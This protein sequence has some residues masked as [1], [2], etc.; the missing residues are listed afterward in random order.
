MGTIMVLILMYSG[1]V[2]AASENSSQEVMA[3]GGDLQKI[4][5][6]EA[7]GLTYHSHVQ[8][9][10]WEPIWVTS[11]GR[12]G[13]EGQSL[14]LEGIEIMLTGDLP[15][16]AK[17]EY[18]AHVENQGWE[19]YWSSNGNAAGSQA[20]SLR[21]EAIQIRLVN[22]PDYTIEYRTHV[23]NKG[24]ES[25]WSKNGETAGTEGQSLRLE[26]IQIR[27]I[28]KNADLTDYNQILAMAKIAVKTDYTSYSWNNLQAVIKANVATVK[29][30][31]EQVDA[32]TE[33]IET[34]YYG[35]ESVANAKVY[36]SAGTYGPGTGLETV[37]QDVIIESDGVILQNI[38]ITGDLIISE[39]VGQGNVTLNNITVDGETYVRGGGKNSIHINGGNYKRITIQ[40]T[41]SGQV[42]IVATN[43]NGLD[44]IIA[45]EAASEEVILEGSFDAVTVNAAKMKISTRSNTT[46]R[47]MTVS[48]VGAGSQITLDDNSRIDRMVFNGKA[49]IKGR[50]A[51]GN[52]Q[53]NANNVTY[54]KAPEQQTVAKTV[55]VPPVIQEIKVPVTAITLAGAGNL[56]SLAKGETLQLTAAIAPSNATNT[57]L[58]WTIVNG[59]GSASVSNTGVVTGLTVGTVTA[60]ATARDGSGKV[61]SLS[62]TIKEPTVAAIAT[63]SSINSGTVNPTFTISLTNDTFTDAAGT[64]SNWTTAMGS[65]GLK[66]AS[67]LRY[68]SN[69]VIIGTTG[70]AAAGS[71]TFKANAAALT[72]NLASNTVTVAVNPIMVS[73]ITVTGFGGAT[74]VNQGSNLQMQATVLPSNAVNTQVT[75][76]V[77]NGTGTATISASGYLTAVTG[78]T[79]T[80]KATAVDG[81][82][83]VGTATITVQEVSAGVIASATTILK[84]AS[85][86]KIVVTLTNDSFSAYAESST[87]WT[88]GT[89]TTGLTVTG[90]TSNSPTQVTISTSGTAAVGSL[91]IQASAGAMSKKVASNTLTFTIEQPV[92][93]EVTVSGSKTVGNT[94]TAA[95]KPTAATVNYQWQRANS[96]DGTYVNIGGATAA[97]YK[98]L[99]GDE[100]KYIK[101]I[102]VGTGNYTA[103]VASVPIMCEK[104]ATV[105]P[106]TASFD[107]ASQADLLITLTPNGKTLKNI[108]DGITNL[109]LETDYTVSGNVYT[110][111]KEY[112]SGKSNGDVTLTFVMS[113]DISTT[114]VVT[115]SGVV[116]GNATVSPTT[117]SFDKSKPDDVVVNL[118]A[119]GRTLTSISD[120]TKNLVLD[121]D[122]TILNNYY[123]IK[124]EYLIQ[125]LVGS[126]TLTFT[127]S[128]GTAPTVACTITESDIIPPTLSNVTTGPVTAGTAVSATST[129]KGRLYLVPAATAANRAAIEVAGS[130]TNG[131]T[132]AVLANQAANL[133]TT[134]LTAGP[135]KVYAIDE[136]GNV[137]NGTEITIN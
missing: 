13:T 72:K 98:L 105:A 6:S 27:I 135:Y 123:T 46:I 21:M 11:G 100:G 53:V 120:G 23:Q 57:L 95:V 66:I 107:K 110:I 15:E 87:L 96:I 1:S 124:K 44:V 130:E 118:S 101:V 83:I 24:W 2:F 109:I 61:G 133:N 128:G 64:L 16:G 84:G 39:A 4:S 19:K 32:A 10:G 49:D 30:T 88:V 36:S 5:T 114:T 28:K 47:E 77:V 54:E 94:L 115:V 127:M 117:V 26:A 45:E 48:K 73:S 129:E 132:I 125:Q 91:T 75:W 136:S 25:V 92:L 121:T 93:S 59:T 9:Y 106:A 40:E 41:A 80:V 58:T 20:Q 33:A 90:V 3:A 108:N 97:T 35:L 112:L 37:S 122:Y 31:Q 89:G 55:K 22:M 79:V 67:V 18:R 69:Q 126:L 42:R 113:D 103:E 14:R 137:S 62:L 71:I 82:A 8:T 17:I 99:A 119:S 56:T 63:V 81:S 131:R 38:H 104:P 12:S 134:G 111:K 65:T 29:S 85:D 116:P 50:G 68:S 86:P 7:V 34:A 102:A 78:G 60:Y 76:S 74:T 70:T 43:S 51:I 52:A